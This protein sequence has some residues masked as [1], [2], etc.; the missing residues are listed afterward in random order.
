M[1]DIHELFYPAEMQKLKDVAVRL[2]GGPARGSVE[3][4]DEKINSDDLEI[5]REWL[6]F[7]PVGS[8]GVPTIGRTNEVS[9]GG[10]V[11]A[12]PGG[13]AYIAAGHG[14]WAMGHLS[15]SGSRKCSFRD[16]AGTTHLG[17]CEW[18]GCSSEWL[19]EIS[20]YGGTGRIL[21]KPSRT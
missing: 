2:M 16:D 14:P 21:K 18:T 19:S 5:I 3:S 10:G 15:F 4:G 17:R 13:G 1:E 6:C 11:R 20:I 9:L 7:R 12:I 8:T